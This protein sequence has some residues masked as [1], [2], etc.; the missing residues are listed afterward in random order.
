[1]LVVVLGLWRWSD[2]VSGRAGAGA[3][4][5]GVIRALRRTWYRPRW[6]WIAVP[7][8]AAIVLGAMLPPVDFDVLEYHLQVPKEWFLAGRVTFLP[9]NVYG[10]MPMGS[11]VLAST[12][13]ALM[14]GPLRWWWGGLAGKVIIAGFA[15]LTAAALYAAGRRFF[16]PLTGVI[17]ALVYLSTT[18]IADVSVNG[19]VDGVLA[20]YGLLAFYALKLWLDDRSMA[21]SR[22]V[23]FSGGQMHAPCVHVSERTTGAPRNEGVLPCGLRASRMG[24][25]M[26]IGLLGGAAAACKYTGVVFIAVPLVAVIGV[27]APRRRLISMTIVCLGMVVGGGLW[28]AKN[29]VL[30]GNP[31]YPLMYRVFDGATRTLAK[32]MQWRTAHQ[33]PRDADG[34]RYSVDQAWRAF[35]RIAGGSRWSHPLMA[36]LVGCI[37]LCW[38]DRRRWAFWLGVTAY[39]LS[40]WWL[41][42]HRID[43]FWIPALPF[44]ALLAGVGAGWTDSIVW[45]RTLWSVLAGTLLVCFLIDTSGVGDNRYFVELEQLRHDPKL[46]NSP[47]AHRYLNAHMDAAHNTLLVG[48]AAVFDLETP[49]LYSTCFDDCRFE[50]IMRG[51][52]PTQ[53]RQALRQLKITRIYV[54]WGEIARYRATYGFTDYVTRALLER[55]E[56]RDHLLRRISIPDLDWNRGVLYEVCE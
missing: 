29:W 36:P 13:M 55:M 21:G 51:R 16:T 38:R 35:V 22:Q 54:D 44:L 26:M 5:P 45:R 41:V 11:E 10:N 14:H 19:L 20:F 2:E 43:R 37:V 9:H 32:D 53:R 4:V 25:L 17:A 33:V 39:V 49:V 30:T 6:W 24:L 47:V 18:W 1:V 12:A 8:A 28:Y 31:T 50:Q 3:E 7:F 40:S 42:T 23:G 52:S 48:D 56:H 27:L 15:P 34:R 46:T